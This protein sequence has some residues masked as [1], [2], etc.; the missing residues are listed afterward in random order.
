MKFDIKLTPE[1]CELSRDLTPL[2][3]RTVCNYLSGMSQLESYKK[4]GGEATNDAS[5][6]ASVST[7]LKNKKVKAFYDSVMQSQA[8]AAAEAGI[9]SRL[10]SLQIIARIANDDENPPAARI[11][12]IKQASDMEG[13]NAPKRAEVT[14]ANGQALELSSTVSAPEVAAAIDGLADKL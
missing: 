7:M 6:S 12:A 3:W 8:E 5:A 10:G 13:W 11:Q 2:Q 14:G 4:A 9:L 1:Q